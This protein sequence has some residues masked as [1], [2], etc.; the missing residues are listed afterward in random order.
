M[1]PTLRRSGAALRLDGIGELRPG[2]A[3]SPPIWPAGERVF[4][5]LM[6]FWRSVT[7]SPSLGGGPADPDPHRV[8]RPAEEGHVADSPIR[9]IRP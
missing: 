3:G 8:V 2:G 6:A 5:C 1:F 4:C 9:L 7:V